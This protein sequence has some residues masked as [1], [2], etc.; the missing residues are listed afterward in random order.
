VKVAGNQSSDS[1]LAD[2][3]SDLSAERFRFPIF[4]L[5]NSAFVGLQVIVGGWVF[6]FCSS[7]FAQ[8]HWYNLSSVLLPT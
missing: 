8:E 1:F 2:Q 5:L 3:L 6:V 7:T 4:S